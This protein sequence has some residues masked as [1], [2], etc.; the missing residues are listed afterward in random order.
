VRTLLQDMHAARQVNPGRFELYPNDKKGDAETPRSRWARAPCNLYFL[1]EFSGYSGTST[2]S[3]PE[4]CG[5]FPESRRGAFVKRVSALSSD[6]HR[7]AGL[8]DCR[9]LWRRR[10]KVVTTDSIRRNEEARVPHAPGLRVG[11]LYLTVTI[12]QVSG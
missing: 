12:D 5:V 4:F 1:Q 6:L 8:R 10:L 7:R 3:P 9:A 11:S 2:T